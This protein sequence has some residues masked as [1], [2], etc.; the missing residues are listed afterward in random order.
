MTPNQG[1]Y[2]I[3]WRVKVFLGSNRGRPPLHKNFRPPPD[4][5]RVAKHRE[6]ER[7]ASEPAKAEEWPES[8]WQAFEGVP[9]DFERSP[10][11]RQTRESFPVSVKESFCYHIHADWD[12]EAGVWVA[13]SD[14]VPGLATEASTLEAL[15]EK[16][17]TMIPELLEANQLPS[18]GQGDAIAIEL[19]SRQ[20]IGPRAPRP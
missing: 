15:A 20:Q 11:V 14:D 6:G 1:I 16:L 13:T 9:E 19:T 17:G 18:N 5:D 2:L 12:P 7:L 8:F 4:T 3:L 10:Q